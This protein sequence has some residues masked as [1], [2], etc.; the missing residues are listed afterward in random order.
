MALM[1]CI[2]LAIALKRGRAAPFLLRLLDY[3]L[4]GN[5]LAK[6]EKIYRADF[7]SGMTLNEENYNYYYIA[8]IWMKWHT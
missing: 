5:K 7:C 2:W 8:R 6:F 3:F 4:I 1:G